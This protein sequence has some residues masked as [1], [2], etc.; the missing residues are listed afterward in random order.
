MLYVMALVLCTGVNEMLIR[1]RKL[2]LEGAGHTVVTAMSD[3][4]VI[5][6]CDKNLFDVAVIGQGVSPTD[7]ERILMLVRQHCPSAKVLELYAVTKRLE[8]ADDLLSVPAKVPV[9]L[10]E[11]VAA[12]A[13]RRPTGRA[14]ESSDPEGGTSR[15]RA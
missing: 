1:S 4:A 3:A 13:T 5:D 14:D 7:K 6:A 12:L 8:G 11:R 10:A 9:E 2:I 15:R